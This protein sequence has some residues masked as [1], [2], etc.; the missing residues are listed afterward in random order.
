[1]RADRLNLQF[2]NE[3]DGEHNR[4][5]LTFMGKL[6]PE[7]TEPD[8]PWVCLEVDDV[9]PAMVFATLKA[10]GKLVDDIIPSFDHPHITVLKNDEAEQLRDKH[11]DEW[12][13]KVGAGFYEYTLGDVVDLDPAGWDEM[14]RVWFVQVDSPQLE[15]LR[16]SLGLKKLPQSEEGKAQDFHITFAVR[17]AQQEASVSETVLES[18][19]E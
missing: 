6:K 5:P 13:D 7:D 15:Q 16:R 18:L 3:I 10:Q 8:K 14:S 4:R 2:L 9:I 11:G 12:K 1:M 17:P 19:M